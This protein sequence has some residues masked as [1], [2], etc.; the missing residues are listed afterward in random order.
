MFHLVGKQE[1]TK[2]VNEADSGNFYRLIFGRD[3]ITEANAEV[4]KSHYA[5][6]LPNRNVLYVSSCQ[7][8][9]FSSN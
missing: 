8:S 3:Q 6:F 1:Y 9:L 5:E 7:M 4:H 2:A